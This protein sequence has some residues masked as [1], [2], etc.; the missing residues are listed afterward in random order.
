MMSTEHELLAANDVEG[1]DAAGSARQD[2]V[3]RLLRIDDDRRNLCRMTGRGTDQVALGQMLAWCDPQ[4][5]LATAQ[6]DCAVRAQRCRE[7]NERNGALV[8]ARLSRVAGMLDML[9]GNL[10]EKTYAPRAGTHAA[11]V[12]TGRMV[13]ISA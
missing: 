11:P 7:Q 6:A 2:T 5:T 1:L 13:S 3:T 10:A 4:G 12:P 8:S 9:S